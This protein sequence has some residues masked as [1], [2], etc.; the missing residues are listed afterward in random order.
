MCSLLLSK[1]GYSSDVVKA[2]VP[3]KSTFHVP[4]L[5]VVE[6]HVNTFLVTLG[7]KS[8]TIHT[9]ISLEMDDVQAIA[10]IASLMAPDGSVI[11]MQADMHRAGDIYVG[12]IMS[13]GTNSIPIDL[14]SG[15]IGCGL[16]IVPV[17]S[18]DGEHVKTVDSLPHF[19]ATMRRT[20]KR[21]KAAEMGAFLSKNIGE[22]IDFYGFAELPQWL[23]EMRFILD[24]VGIP[25]SSYDEA[26]TDSE[27]SVN[28][29]GRLTRDQYVVL[30]YIGRYAQSL[31]SSGNHFMEL[32][33]DDEGF[34]WTVVHSGSRGLGAK[35][36]EAI[37]KAA[38]ILTGGFE[39]ATGALATFYARA[40]DALNK[41]AKLNRVMCSVAVLQDMG[42]ETSAP[43]L[44]TH[45][46]QSFMFKDAMTKVGH[47]S[48]AMLSL[49]SGLTH[50][51]IK[52]FVNDTTKE[53][54]FVLSK[55][56]IAMTKRASA[57]IVALRAGDGCFVW[58]LADLTC[59]WRE[60]DVRD[61]IAK[62]EDDYRIVHESPD[63]IYSGHGAG[64]SRSTNLTAKMSTF[65]D[66]MAFYEE[67]NVVGN[68]A[69]GILGDHPRIAYN[70]VD[71]IVKLLPLDISCTKSRLKTLVS[72][73]EGITYSKNCMDC[74]ANYIMKKWDSS[75]DDVKLWLDINVCQRSMSK[76]DYK[77]MDDERSIILK[78]LDASIVHKT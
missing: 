42:Y 76:R 52:A 60:C 44:K 10:C 40:Y 71:T 1:L 12:M 58:T 18:L 3:N 7:P 57:S 31:G 5:V 25:F 33:V 56:A 51:G 43:I 78:R 54:L 27:D 16:S 4:G 61:A 49:M 20:L 28:A 37:S 14:V 45:M 70:D 36:Y 17:V 24:M 8:W 68:I 9:K 50:N 29:A 55:G 75:S 22:A 64:R 62:T 2:T 19:L 65:E 26:P 59:Q 53:I 21:G 39:V 46:K 73:K 63:I 23:D 6:T 11:N 30:K 32:A 66:V 35:V 34:Y 74:C 38:R 67:S 41:F 15:D 48:D 47:D 13:F 72:Y 77:R 69:P